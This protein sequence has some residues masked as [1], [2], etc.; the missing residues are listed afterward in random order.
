MIEMEEDESTPILDYEVASDAPQSGLLSFVLSYFGA[1]L[2][3]GFLIGV[4]LFLWK[5]GA[6]YSGDLVIGV[7][8]WMVITVVVLI[9]G[10]L[11]QPRAGRQSI[12]SGVWLGVCSWST[13]FA[14]IYLLIVISGQYR[15][16]GSP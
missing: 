11:V 8:L 14:I 1:S 9:A 16:H 2:T 5:L 6:F 4:F 7:F 12:L 15:V 10:A 13:A 3:V